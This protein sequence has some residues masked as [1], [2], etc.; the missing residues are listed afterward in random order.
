MDAPRD[1]HSEETSRLAQGGVCAGAYAGLTQCTISLFSSSSVAHPPYD[2]LLLRS[3]LHLR[4]WLPLRVQSPLRLRALRRPPRQSRRSQRS[5]SGRSMASASP[6][7]CGGSGSASAS[8]M[9]PSRQRRGETS[10][11]SDLRLGHPMAL[12]YLQPSPYT[13]SASLDTPHRYI[14][15]IAT[16]STSLHTPHRYIPLIATYPDYYIPI[17]LAPGLLISHTVYQ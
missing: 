9:R 14:P 10:Y 3:L 12:G 11:D 8:G 4:Y 15:H 6:P 2:R 17:A 1:L 16:Y 13:Y 5:W 7:G